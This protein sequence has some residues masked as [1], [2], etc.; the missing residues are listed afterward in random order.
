M[1]H[2]I[3]LIGCEQSIG[4]CFIAPSMIKFQNNFSTSSYYWLCA[5]QSVAIYN[6]SGRN[7]Y[8]ILGFDMLS[9]HIS[10]T[11]AT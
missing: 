9:N 5:H 1:L 3:V 10:I 11:L 8:M 6:L 2:H 7:L 4:I